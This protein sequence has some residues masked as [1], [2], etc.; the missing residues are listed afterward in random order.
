MNMDIEKLKRE[1]EVERK[2]KDKF[3]KLGYQFPVSW[4]KREYFKGLNYYSH[5]FRELLK[6]FEKK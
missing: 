3:F 4:K 2:Q 5:Y 1:I 6:A